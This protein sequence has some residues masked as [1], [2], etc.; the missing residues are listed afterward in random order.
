MPTTVWGSYSAIEAGIIEPKTGKMV[1]TYTIWY[2]TS[3][4]EQGV[5]TYT[6]ATK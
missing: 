2:G 1:G 5:H 6:K 4:I 3:V